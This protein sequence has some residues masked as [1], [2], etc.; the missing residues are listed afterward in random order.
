MKSLFGVLWLL[1]AP[2]VVQTDWGKIDYDAKE[3][4]A[5]GVATPTIFSPTGGLSQGDPDSAAMEDAKRRLKM[6][7]AS[8]PIRVEGAAD[9]GA[10]EKKFVEVYG[11]DA[12]D[13]AVQQATFSMRHFTDGTVHVTATVPLP[14]AAWKDG[15]DVR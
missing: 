14:E 3:V 9:A 1:L 12:V 4:S 11:A 13:R 8:I 7:V 5:V 2:H 10:S 6:L 15:G